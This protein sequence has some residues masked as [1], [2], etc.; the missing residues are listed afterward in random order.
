M[1]RHLCGAPL[2]REGY[3]LVRE[4][5]LNRLEQSPRM[6]KFREAPNTKGPFDIRFNLCLFKERRN[7]ILVPVYMPYHWN[8]LFLDSSDGCVTQLM[9]ESNESR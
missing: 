5:L 8:S 4:E 6:M 1:V 9:C 2:Q 3:K 7:P